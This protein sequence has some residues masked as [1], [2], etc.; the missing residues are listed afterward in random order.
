MKQLD[1][2][3]LAHKVYNNQTQELLSFSFSEA[4]KLAW[5]L[6]KQAKVLIQD[7]LITL[8]NT[9]LSQYEL[10]V[11]VKRGR[12]SIEFKDTYRNLKLFPYYIKHNAF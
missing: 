11:P 7:G 9:I 4:L 5:R 6:C 1:S 3:S 2:M 12:K 10:C 8:K